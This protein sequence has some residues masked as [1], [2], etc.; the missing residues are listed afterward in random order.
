MDKDGSGTITVDE[1]K[2]ALR[3]ANKVFTEE[4]FEQLWETYDV[5]G[6]QKEM[7]P[8]SAY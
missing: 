4:Y 3:A 7:C 2:D 6:M 5:D 1:M 8:P